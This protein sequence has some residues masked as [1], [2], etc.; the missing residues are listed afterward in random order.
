MCEPLITADRAAELLKLHP[1]TV[2]RLAQAG[3]TKRAGGRQWE[4]CLLTGR[5]GASVSENEK[6]PRSAS[7]SNLKPLD[8]SAVERVRREAFAVFRGHPL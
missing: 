4:L 5:Y 8:T 1:K 3:A 7:R 2:K 6:D